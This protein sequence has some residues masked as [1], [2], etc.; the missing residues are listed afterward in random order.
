VNIR[1]LL[2]LLVLL[3]PIQGLAQAADESP[4]AELQVQDIRCEGNERVACDF[5]RGHLYLSPGDALDEDE[6]RNAELRLSALRYFGT[7]G[8]HLE[9]GA[10]RGSVI[11]VIDVTETSPLV[12]ETI[13]GGSYRL[14]SGRMLVGSRIAHQNLF[15]EGKLADLTAV[16]GVPISGPARNELYGVGLRYVDPLMFDSRRW[17]GVVNVNW[18]KFDYE[19]Q[20]GNFAHSE[21]LSLGATAGWRFAD[22][23]YLTAG[24]GYQPSFEASSGFWRR[25]GTFDVQAERDPYYSF[26]FAYGWN[27]EDDLLFPTQGSTLELNVGV[28]H[29]DETEFGIWIPQFRKTWGWLGAYWTVKIGGDPTPE[30]RFS[31]AEN[32][33]LAITYARPVQAGDNVRRGRWYIEPGYVQPVWTNDGR[34]VYEAG[35]K[36]GFRA[37]TRAFGYVDLYLM[38]S[39]DVNK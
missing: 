14:E 11:V 7:V 27:S 30:Y 13:A 17:F 22:F 21:A 6:I 3:N 1:S 8:I 23:S 15:G 25:D 16:T 36:V 20:Y 2:C 39:V 33:P 38:G 24:V 19:D 9:K 5:I 35:L 28:G 32:Q 18:S 26:S 4:S 12:M 34:H 29:G 10:R 37:D 31:V